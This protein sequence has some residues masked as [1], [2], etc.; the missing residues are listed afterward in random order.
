[1][2]Q[3]AIQIGI[4]GCRSDS[5]SGMGFYIEMPTL[6]VESVLCSVMKK[7][8]FGVFLPGMGQF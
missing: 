7:A 4:I 5:I 1:M 8:W 3:E 2:K 6:W